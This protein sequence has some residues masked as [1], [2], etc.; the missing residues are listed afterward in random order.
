MSSLYPR[1]SSL[2]ERIDAMRKEQL[3]KL[4]ERRERMKRTSTWRPPNAMR[5]SRT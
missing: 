5:R 4:D 2:L 3:R 1:D